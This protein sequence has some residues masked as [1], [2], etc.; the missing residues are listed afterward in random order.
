M[1]WLLIDYRVIDIY[2]QVKQNV[3]EGNIT[4]AKRLFKKCYCVTL[5]SMIFTFV[6]LI[7][8]VTTV[9]V[10]VILSLSMV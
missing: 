7:V 10:S 5:A 8:F 3:R 9:P 1:R 2:I 6:F 4:Q